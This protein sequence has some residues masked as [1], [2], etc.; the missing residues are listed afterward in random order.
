M[1]ITFQPIAA[2]AIPIEL[3]LL[4]DPELAQVERYLHCSQGYALY[5]QAVIVAA[6]LVQPV[7]DTSYELMNIAT[8]VDQQ[9]Q[10]YGSIL[11]SKLISCLKQQGI[12]QLSVATGSFGYQLSFYQRLGFRV[13]KIEHDYFTD[14]YSEAI[15]EDG[16]Q[17]RDRLH[18]TVNLATNN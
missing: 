3:L 15:W 14:H 2:Q 5:K 13:I 9:Q 6:C 4:A 16:I 10:G 12:K 17:H 18:L 7:T 8:A 11:L 1:P